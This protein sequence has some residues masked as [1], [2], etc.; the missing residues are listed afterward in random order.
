MRW[1]P[2]ASPQGCTPWWGQRPVWVSLQINVEV[3]SVTL[4][5]TKGFKLLC[6]HRRV[7]TPARFQ[8]LTVKLIGV[9]LRTQTSVKQIFNQ[10][11]FTV[12][13]LG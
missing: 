6:C 7:V 9:H 5:D 2:T 3:D 11:L 10:C 8:G 13:F 1:E 4:V 12:S